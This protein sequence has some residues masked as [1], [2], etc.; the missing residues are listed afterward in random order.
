MLTTKFHNPT[1][2]AESGKSVKRD[3]KSR[4]VSAV[5]SSSAM[6]RTKSASSGIKVKGPKDK[7]RRA[8]GVSSNSL[9]PSSSRMSISRSYSILG[10]VAEVPDINDV[11]SQMDV[12]TANTEALIDSRCYELTVSPLADVSTAYLQS[13]KS[14]QNAEIDGDTDV[15]DGSVRIFYYAT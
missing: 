7:D 4:K 6:R 10:S 5:S 2:S 15:E 13:T 1:I 11:Q 14:L 12:V 8:L 9:R 3:A